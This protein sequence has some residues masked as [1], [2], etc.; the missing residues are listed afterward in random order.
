MNALISV[1]IFVVVVICL[2]RVVRVLTVVDRV[3]HAV[4]VVIRIADVAQTVMIVVGLVR[5]LVKLAVIDR[6]QDAQVLR[7]REML[8][9]LISLR[10]VLFKR[11]PA[12]LFPGACR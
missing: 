2:V 6:V 7:L 11:A 5:V 3:R 1:A 10:D 9:P 12:L 4:V 8:V